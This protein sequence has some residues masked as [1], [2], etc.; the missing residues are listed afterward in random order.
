[1]TLFMKKEIAALSEI[2]LCHAESCF[3]LNINIY[4]SLCYQSFLNSGPRFSFFLIWRCIKLAALL[5]LRKVRPVIINPG[6]RDFSP[7]PD[8]GVYKKALDP[9]SGSATLITLSE[10]FDRRLVNKCYCSS[11]LLRKTDPN[12]PFSP[13]LPHLPFSKRDCHHVL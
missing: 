3:F 9:G 4:R 12:I 6:D 8:P 13:S 5:L 1:M 11:K 2:Q 7:I 10:T